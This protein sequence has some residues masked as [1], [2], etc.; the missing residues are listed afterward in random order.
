MS[1]ILDSSI[2]FDKHQEATDTVAEIEDELKKFKDDHSR[3]PK[4]KE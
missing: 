1:M 4:P 3:K 2:D